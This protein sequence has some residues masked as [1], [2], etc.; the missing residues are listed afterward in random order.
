MAQLKDILIKR[1]M[2]K[3]MDLDMIPGFI[4][5][6]TNSYVYYPH[7]DFKQ[8]NDR[9]KYMGWD[10]FELDYFTFQLVL[11][12]LEGSGLKR[13]EYKSSQWYERNFCAA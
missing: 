8:I 3:G 5:S 13:S 12:C 1:L 2:K 11:E 4:R 7:V 10:D 6:L 9:L